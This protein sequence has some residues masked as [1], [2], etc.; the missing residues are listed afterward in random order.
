MAITL[1]A[2]EDFHLHRPHAVV[3]LRK[4]GIT[5]CHPRLLYLHLVGAVVALVAADLRHLTN[6]API[7][8]VGPTLSLEHSRDFH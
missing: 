2:H 7:P 4:H 5:Q 6:K 8:N 3:V 1:C